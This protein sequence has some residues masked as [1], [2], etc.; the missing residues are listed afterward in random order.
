MITVAHGF[1]VTLCVTAVVASLPNPVG[2]FVTLASATAESFGGKA[3]LITIG[4]ETKDVGEAKAFAV[5]RSWAV[6][7]L[8]V[9]ASLAFA[10]V[11]GPTLRFA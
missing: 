9:A 3:G 1:Y 8:G 10:A 6:L 7:G 5:E 2:L 11:L 4:F